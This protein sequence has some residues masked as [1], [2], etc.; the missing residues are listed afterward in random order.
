VFGQLIDSLLSP[1]SGRIVSKSSV[2]HS[3]FYY[4][5][6]ARFA[7]DR[8]RVAKKLLAVASLSLFLFLLLDSFLCRTDP[9]DLFLFFWLEDLCAKFGR[10]KTVEGI[11]QPFPALH[12]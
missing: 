6:A 10:A 2:A 8:K 1:V 12:D 4:Q 5:S 7:M 11:C 3:G 9:R